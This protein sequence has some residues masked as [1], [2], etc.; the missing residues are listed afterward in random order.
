M[1]NPF[2]VAFFAQP[3]E[4]GSV[5]ILGAPASFFPDPDGSASWLAEVTEEQALFLDTVTGYSR[6]NPAPPAALVPDKTW[7]VMGLIRFAQDTYGLTLAPSLGK[8]GLLTAIAGAQA[9]PAAPAA[10]APSE[11]AAPDA[12][13]PVAPSAPSTGASATEGE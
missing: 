5:S 12:E 1:P 6:W 13:A 9:A 7:T 8:A 11:A 4:D 3:S 10:P 2:I